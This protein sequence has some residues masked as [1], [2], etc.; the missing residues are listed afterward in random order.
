MGSVD[1]DGLRE[2]AKP[3]FS[4]RDRLQELSG[5]VDGM[6]AASAFTQDDELGQKGTEG[7]NSFRAAIRDA[8]GQFS[9]G[10][11][12]LGKG[13]DLLGR[14]AIETEKI[15][16]EQAGLVPVFSSLEA[17]SK[18]LEARGNSMA[19]EA[20]DLN[21]EG[22]GLE[23]E[24]KD[25]DGEAASLDA[26]S[27]ALEQERRIL[28]STPPGAGFDERS[29]QFNERS[30]DFNRR[31]QVFAERAK[32]FNESNN[33]FTG[34][35]ADFNRRSDALQQESEGLAQ[36]GVEANEKARIAGE[37]SARHSQNLVNDQRDF[38]R[39][40]AQADLDRAQKNADEAPG[41]V[42]RAQE[43]YD[44]DGSK[45]NKEALE[46]AKKSAAQA[47]RV[48]ADA[49][50]GLAAA[51]K[52]VAES[53]AAHEKSTSD[54]GKTQSDGQAYQAGANK[55]RADHDQSV[56]DRTRGEAE[57]DRSAGGASGA[58]VAGGASGG[59]AP[60]SSVG[61][62]DAGASVGGADVG[63]PAS[64][65][66]RELVR[67]WVPQA[68]EISSAPSD[69][70]V[71][72]GSPVDPSVRRTVDP[73]PSDPDGVSAGGSPPQVGVAGQ[74]DRVASSDPV[75]A[76]DDAPRPESSTRATDVRATG[77]GRALASASMLDAMGDVDS[78]GM[79]H[80][81]QRSDVHGADQGS[82]DNPVGGQDRPQAN[83]DHS[84]SQHAE[85]IHHSN[86]H[87]RGDS[88]H[89]HDG[90]GEVNTLPARSSSRRGVKIW[91]TDAKD[92]PS[93]PD[94]DFDE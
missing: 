83:G 72:G 18:R 16:E 29:K 78:A 70:R 85:D 43:A 1:G 51:D 81:A 44:K 5:L 9:T 24:S 32:R 50:S 92:A 23:R 13:T 79:R 22:K 3:F 37:N 84:H 30:E 57:A 67:T 69:D 80:N 27:A 58:P 47:P 17:D 20:D 42:Q 41:R 56:A 7:D 75:H 2:A 62:S 55:M 87:R 53:Q 33:R 35:N 21:R 40:M 34:R 14:R 36:R 4:L 86:S 90:S 26:E 77:G 39:P 59:A 60:R 49:Q 88:A 74:S 91:Q 48:L 15:N 63:G 65:S 11:E 82:R 45:E 76:F 8:L 64:R 61:G 94:L 73:T 6:S 31:N 54:L 38:Y 93:E 28:E 10:M 25:L 71:G 46:E 52:S 12:N 68:P 19:G 89:A 66:E